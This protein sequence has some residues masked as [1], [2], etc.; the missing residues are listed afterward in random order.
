MRTSYAYM[1]GMYLGDG[2]ISQL[3][4]DV[5]SLRISLDARYPELVAEC[6]ARLQI[7]CP[8][9]RVGVVPMSGGAHGVV[10]QAYSRH[11][12]CM[13]PQHGPGAKHTRSIELAEWQQSIINDEPEL[14]LRGLIHSDGCRIVNNR[15]RGSTWTGIRYLFSNRSDDIRALFGATCDRLR[16]HWTAPDVYTISVARREDTARLDAFIGP[17]Q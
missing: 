11:W 12:P 14:F 16:I 13:F 17:K 9:N 5:Y 15:G 2:C 6:R 7:L 1:A 3:R 4:K 8:D 10:V